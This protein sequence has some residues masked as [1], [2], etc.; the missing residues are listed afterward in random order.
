MVYRALQEQ[1][2]IG[3]IKVAVS[4]VSPDMAD[5]IADKTIEVGIDQQYYMQASNC[6][7]FLHSLLQTFTS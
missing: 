1:N 4:D 3:H 2:M 7:T 5:L 6:A